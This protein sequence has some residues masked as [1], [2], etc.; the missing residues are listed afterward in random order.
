MPNPKRVL[1]RQAKIKDAT[2]ATR[3]RLRSAQ[4]SGE[5]DRLAN[6]QKDVLRTT[7]LAKQGRVLK[8]KV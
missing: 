6:A 4:A 8:K 1:T 5:P 2:S 7:F 3:T